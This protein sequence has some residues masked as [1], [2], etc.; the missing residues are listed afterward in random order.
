MAD[1]KKKK[2][3]NDLISTNKTVVEHRR[4]R[5][6][7]HIEETF[8]AGLMLKGTEVK[9]LRKGQCSINEAYCIDKDGEIWIHGAHIAEYMQA[10]KHLQHDPKRD[11]M[12][13]LKK[14]EIARLLGASTRDGYSII[15]MR[16]FFDDR[17]YAKL[18]IG[19]GKG[20]KEFDKRETSKQRDWN[21]QKNRVLR[22]AGRE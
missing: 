13:L 3:K 20:K 6:D 8:T 15:P 19:L 22:D 11:R 12:L 14:K 9:S 2:S 18:D 16:L 4:A 10:G 21:K 1:N 7:Y 5:Y 17:G